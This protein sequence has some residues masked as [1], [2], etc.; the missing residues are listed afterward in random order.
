MIKLA[1]QI[2]VRPAGLSDN[3]VVGRHNGERNRVVA[4][5]GAE[6]ASITGGSMFNGF[7]S[8]GMLNSRSMSYINGAMAQYDTLLSG[9]ISEDEENLYRFYRDM[10]HYDSVAG[11]AVDLLSTLPFSE[12]TL[13]GMDKEKIATYQTSIERLSFKTI[14]PEISVEYLVMGKFIGSL[15]VKASKKVFTDM[16]SHTPENATIT[17]SPFMSVDPIIRMKQSQAVREFLASDDKRLRE[18]REAMNGSFLRALRAEEMV[19]DPATTLFL[20]RK[21]FATDIKGTSFLKRVLP[22]YLIEKTLYRGTIIEAG[23]RQRSL[24]HLEM[25]ESGE[26]GTYPGRTASGRYLVPTGRPRSFRRYC[27]H[28]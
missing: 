21:T 2:K 4:S 12:F 1:N 3:L 8:G 13:V 28:P 14:L 16:M 25:G 26:W 7:T 24:L 17:P 23:R 27:C 20:P 18:I 9:L 22:V 6:T 15:V 19:L 5:G 11:S 10:Y